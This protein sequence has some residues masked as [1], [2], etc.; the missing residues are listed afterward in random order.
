VG[1][2]LVRAYP[3]YKIVNLD[4]LEYCSSLKNLES[5]AGA[6]NYTFVKGSITSQE[7]VNYIMRKEGIDTVMHFAA[8]THVDNSFGNSIAFTEC[9]V[10]GTHVLLE[11]AKEARVKL[12]MHVS[13]DEVYGDGESGV[14]SHEGSVLEPTNPYSASKAGAE[15]LVKAYHRSFDLPIIITRGNNV[16]GP[17]QYPEK[18]IPKFV[19]QLIRGL[20]ITLHGT[21]AN[22][23]NYLYVEDVAA[24][25]DTVLHAGRVGEV[26]N[27]GG[28]NVHSNI[29]VARAILYLMGFVD[30]AGSLA[31]AEARHV[32]YV[33]DRPFND[34]GYPLDCA[35]LNAIGWRETTP[36]EDGLRRTV[37]WYL[38]HPTHW[39]PADV[40]SAIV[41]HPRRGY[42][43]RE[44]LEGVQHDDDDASPSD[45]IDRYIRVRTSSLGARPDAA[46]A[47]AQAAADFVGSGCAA[48][49]PALVA[50]TGALVPPVPAVPAAATSDVSPAP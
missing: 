48:L 36:W 40:E 35:R 14:A 20:P 6:P 5:I 44:V 39:H 11:A 49:P 13:T 30:K 28:T 17:H 38:R 50:P 8:Q 22:T 41:P 4:K 3:Q 12:F 16:Y 19:N 18:I 24:A 32:I 1:I 34:L 31:A 27:I 15:Y 47:A 2:R 43:P 9:N 46:L 21:G 33:Q 42:L 29:D 23:R 7:L 26:Y 10:L 45:P 25:F 37:A